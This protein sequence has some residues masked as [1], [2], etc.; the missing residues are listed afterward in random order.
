[1]PWAGVHSSL[2][3]EVDKHSSGSMIGNFVLA[4]PDY[5]PLCTPSS[6]TDIKEAN[7]L[8]CLTRTMILNANDAWQEQRDDV[9]TW[10][11]VY[12]SLLY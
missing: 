3:P 4:T 9:K 12:S 8:P 11:Q 7:R 5:V 10:Q 2:N 1:M 6:H